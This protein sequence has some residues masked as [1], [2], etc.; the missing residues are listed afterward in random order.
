LEGFTVEN[1]KK[2]H[3]MQESSRTIGK[4]VIQF[5]YKTVLSSS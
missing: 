3:Q 4:T 5:S 2:A 1:L